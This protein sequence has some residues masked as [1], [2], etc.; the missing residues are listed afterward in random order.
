MY[1]YLGSVSTPLSVS[2]KSKVAPK[3]A[4]FFLLLLLLL[5]GRGLGVV[6]VCILLLS[7]VVVVVVSVEVGKVEVVEEEVG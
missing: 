2:R 1:V 4:F 6:E 5:S 3:A 7:G